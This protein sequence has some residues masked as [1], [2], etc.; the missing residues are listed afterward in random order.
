MGSVL[1]GRKIVQFHGLPCPLKKHSLASLAGGRAWK[2][3]QARRPWIPAVLPRGSHCF[4]R[5]K[6]SQF[7]VCFGS[8]YSALKW[9]FWTVFPVLCL[10][11]SPHCHLQKPLR[12]L[13]SRCALEAPGEASRA[14]SILI[15]CPFAP[16]QSSPKTA[17]K[18]QKS[19][20]FRIVL[21]ERFLFPRFPTVPWDRQS[22]VRIFLI[23]NLFPSCAILFLSP[24]TCKSGSRSFSCDCP[25]V[26][27]N[28][29]NEP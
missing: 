4:S 11:R 12:Q 18:R 17:P 9:S 15:A 21:Q 29:V 10:F 19:L 14:G 20:P 22:G 13:L 26:F 2:Q 5:I 8:I 25:S 27:F 24:K 1:S 6:A 3:L 16:T 7:I 28:A 23:L